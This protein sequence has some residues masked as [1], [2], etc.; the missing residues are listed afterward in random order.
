M[1]ADTKTR[2]LTERAATAVHAMHG[3]SC[4]ANR[5]DPDPIFCTSFGDDCTGPPA[6]PGSRED[7]LVDN[8]AAVPKSC[9]PPLEMRSPTAAGGLLP[10]GEASIAMRSSFNQPPLRLYSA[11]EANSKETRLNT[12]HTIAASEGIACLLSPPAG[13]SSK[14]NRGKI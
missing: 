3:D 13:G 11:E 4:S 5:V 1:Q 10:T 6:L 12:P 2:E 7:A 9:R 14:Q 8:G